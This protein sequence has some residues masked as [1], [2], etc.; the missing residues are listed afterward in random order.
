[1]CLKTR[2]NKATSVSDINALL[3][4]PKN[5][6]GT[7]FPCSTGTLFPSSTASMSRMS[8]RK[9]VPRNEQEHFRAF[10]SLA[11]Q[12]PWIIPAYLLVSGKT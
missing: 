12:A 11:A 1:M 7:I 8:L 4:V 9:N 2:R 10:S 6:L 5:Y 3:V